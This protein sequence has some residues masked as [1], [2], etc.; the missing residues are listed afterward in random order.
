MQAGRRDVSGV[1]SDERVAAKEK[2]KVNKMVVRP[3]V[4]FGLELEVRV[5]ARES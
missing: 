4:L 3:G 5:T 1:N 2:G